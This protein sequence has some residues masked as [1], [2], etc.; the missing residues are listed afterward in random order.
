MLFI[1]SVRQG[2][3]TG[4]RVVLSN[5]FVLFVSFVVRESCMGTGRPT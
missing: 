2:S 5:P 3:R 4:L 1:N